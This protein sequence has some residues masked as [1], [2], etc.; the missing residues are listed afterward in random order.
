MI[1][2]KPIQKGISKSYIKN[3]PFEGTTKDYGNRELLGL[4]FN[5][6]DKDVIEEIK[7]RRPRLTKRAKLR[8][9]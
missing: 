8:Y 2:I 3:R 1:S 4:E 5:S 6:D 9:K 7:K